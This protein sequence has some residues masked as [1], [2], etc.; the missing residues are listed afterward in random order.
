[1]ITCTKRLTFCAGHR[2]RGHENKC[3]HLHGHNYVVE[4]TVSLPI[5][6]SDN[7]GRVVDF[8]VLKDRV[9]TW[10]DHY[11]DHGFI[12]VKGDIETWMALQSFNQTNLASSRPFTQKQF[13]MPC[14]PTAEN[15]ALYLATL[16]IPDLLQ[17]TQLRVEGVTVW[18]TETCKGTWTR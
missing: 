4:V 5:Q 1:M 11:W 15:M 10:I 2:V 16:I 17:D 9:G 8:S 7:I 3:A 6:K 18:E 14:N 12:F 13:E